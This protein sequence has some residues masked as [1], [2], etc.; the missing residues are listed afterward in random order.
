[1]FARETRRAHA[2]PG[3][4]PLAHSPA[5]AQGVGARLRKRRAA[6]SGRLPLPLP[7]SRGRPMG[8]AQGPCR[9]RP[10]QPTALGLARAARPPAPLRRGP[11]A[12]D[13]R[14]PGGRTASARPRLP[15]LGRAPAAPG[16]RR[17]RRPRARAGARWSLP[18]SLA[19]KVRPG[20]DVVFRELGGETVLLNLRTGVYYGLNETRAAPWSPRGGGR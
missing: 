10:H 2:P 20:R 15:L 7:A 13:G 1:M 19:N 17:R 3:R 14:R 8:D 9:P 5:A 18:M 6:R 11:A 12:A 4:A 16:G